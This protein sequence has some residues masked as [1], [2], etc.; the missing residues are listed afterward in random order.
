MCFSFIALFMTLSLG[1]KS[2]CPLSPW[3]FSRM[4]RALLISS[5]GL[6]DFIHAVTEGPRVVVF[7]QDPHSNMLQPLRWS[8]TSS[9]TDEYTEREKLAGS[10]TKPNRDW[11]EKSQLL[12]LLGSRC[13]YVNTQPTEQGNSTVSRSSVVGICSGTG[14]CIYFGDQLYILRLPSTPHPPSPCFTL[15]VKYST[16][17]YHFILLRLFPLTVVRGRLDSESLPLSN[18]I[19]LNVKKGRK[20]SRTL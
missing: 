8:L 15:S 20:K 16:V 17:Y 11:R 1:G 13:S 10:V 4:E 12:W 3:V 9:F 19:C 6:S 18:S 2:Q 14:D 7:C 5:L